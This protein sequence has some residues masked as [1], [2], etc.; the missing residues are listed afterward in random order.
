MKC[1][2]MYKCL[3][4]WHKRHLS[5]QPQWQPHKPAQPWICGHLKMLIKRS[6]LSKINHTTKWIAY[7][8]KT[9]NYLS[10]IAR[11][12]RI[13]C[14]WWV[15]TKLVEFCVFQTTPLLRSMRQDSSLDCS[16]IT[17]Y[18][19]ILLCSISW[20]FRIRWQVIKVYFSQRL[21]CTYIITCTW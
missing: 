21:S 3:L 20:K 14:R 10:R 2:Y 17:S 9:F 16:Q 8:N 13:A 15:L 6:I 7:L 12:R 1:D 5:I 11:S 19:F 4:R 18:K